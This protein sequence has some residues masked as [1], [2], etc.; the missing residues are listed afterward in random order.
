MKRYLAWFTAALIGA[1]VGAS[2]VGSLYMRAFRVAIPSKIQ[3]ME[4][5]QRYRCVLSMAVLERLDTNEPD[6]AK[7]LLTREVVSYYKH[8]LG[9][10]ESPE[11]KKVLEHIDRLRGKSS[12][13]NDAFDKET[14]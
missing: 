1:A 3:Q 4:D 13:L 12:A 11:R 10:A 8:P 2:V 7:L 5:E 9:L 14:Q 6:R